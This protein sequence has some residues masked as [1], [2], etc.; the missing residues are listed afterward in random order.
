MGVVGDAE[1]TVGGAAARCGLAPHPAAAITAAT[2]A[3]ETRRIGRRL[4]GVM[5]VRRPTTFASAAVAL[6]ALT[7]CTGASHRTVPLVGS[8]EAT[9][10]AAPD[11]PTPTPT[12]KPTPTPT[13]TP[14]PTPPP[15]FTSS[16]ATVTA[17]SL[18]KSWH[19]GCPVGPDRLRALTLTYW[20]FDARAHTG[21]LIVAT[22][23]VSAMT[24][25]WRRMYDARFPIRKVTPVSAYGGDDNKSM[26][27]DNTSAF[28]CRYAVADGPKHWSA[29]A[30]G[31]A[32][33]IDPYENPY[34][35]DGRVYPPG[36]TTYTHRDNVR[37]GMIVPGSAPVRA[38]SA[39]GWGWGGRWSNSPDYQHFSASGG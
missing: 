6:F 38:F 39:V 25:A 26:A 33:D 29:H 22:V 27:A 1:A 18:G 35:L 37:P 12:P 24:E 2:I 11:S 9:L 31:Q 15:P 8:T 32:V 19:E 10:S 21:T 16:V 7:A 28:N 17:A 34:T 20:G 23:A 4:T 5:R 30:Y 36:A 3:G 13:P 14:K